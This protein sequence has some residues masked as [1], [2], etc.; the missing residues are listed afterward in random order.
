MRYFI[1]EIVLTVAAYALGL[2]F[3]IAAIAHLSFA[4]GWLFGIGLFFPPVAVINGM[5]ILAGMLTQ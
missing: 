4:D 3:I 2:T 5:F 1:N